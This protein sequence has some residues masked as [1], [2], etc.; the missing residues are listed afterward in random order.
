[1][2]YPPNDPMLRW[3]LLSYEALTTE[4]GVTL[5]ITTNHP[6]HLYVLWTSRN[7][8][9]HVKLKDYRGTPIG[10]KTRYC[11]VA[12]NQVFQVEAGDTTT[13]TFDISPWPPKQQ[14]WFRFHGTVG[15]QDSPS[16]S[17]CLTYTRGVLPITFYLYPDKHPEVTSC[18]GYAQRAVAGQTWANIHDGPG[19]S[20]YDQDINEIVQITSSATRNKWNVIRRT[21]LV[22]DSSVIA[23]KYTILSAVFRCQASYRTVVVGW[24]SSINLY[25]SN[26]LQYTE[27]SPEDYSACGAIPFSS[28]ISQSNWIPEAW[29]QFILNEAGLAAIIKEG[30]TCMSLREATYD[31][32]N[33]PPGWLNHKTT[34]LGAYSADN[35]DPRRPYLE[36]RAIET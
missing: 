29:Q 14:R 1:M 12:T 33:S 9:I 10:R 5:T 20:A 30:T 4:A 32:S 13:H 36:V 21:I 2:T 17:P 19:T 23:Q 25:S 26:P 24:D 15:T 8:W 3:A 16:D 27:V 11:C 28:P 18:D 34:A 35:L 31:V 22:F 7:P 6:C